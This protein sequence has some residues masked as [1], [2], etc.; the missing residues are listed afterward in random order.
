MI[1]LC[2]GVNSVFSCRKDRP[3]DIFKNGTH[4]SETNSHG[5]VSVQGVLPKSKKKFCAFSIFVC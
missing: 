1:F 3:S 2:L 5:F 4:K